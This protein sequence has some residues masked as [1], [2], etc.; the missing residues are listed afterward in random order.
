MRL[1]PGKGEKLCGKKYIHIQNV[2]I[3]LY[4]VL[5]QTF[6]IEFN[7]SSGSNIDWRGLLQIFFMQILQ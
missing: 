4:V 7:R 5:Q 3:I 1:L 2:L 6:R